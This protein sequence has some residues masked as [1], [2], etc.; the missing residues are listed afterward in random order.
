MIQPV[1]VFSIVLYNY[2]I[3][4]RCLSSLSSKSLTEQ[5]NAE[6]FHML[7]L[8]YYILTSRRILEH[9]DTTDIRLVS[10]LGRLV[11]LSL[12]MGM[13]DVHNEYSRRLGHLQDLTRAFVS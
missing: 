2:G 9:H 1:C 4:Y 10:L 3:A 5:L 13:K 7:H 8:A 6:A 11:D 12:Q